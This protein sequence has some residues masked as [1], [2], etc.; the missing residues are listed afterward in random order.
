VAASSSSML[1]CLPIMTNAQKP[2]EMLSPAK[3]AEVAGMRRTAFLRHVVAGAIKPDMISG[4]QKFFKRSTVDAWIAARERA[5]IRKR[6]PKP[7]RERSAA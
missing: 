4:T 5:G 3:A 1:E 7:Q 6:G 2:D